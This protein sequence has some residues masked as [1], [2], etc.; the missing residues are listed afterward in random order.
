MSY[1]C[2]SL[3]QPWASAIVLLCKSIETRHWTTSYRGPLLIHAS[4]RW[5][6]EQRKIY[7][8][9]LDAGVLPIHSPGARTFNEVYPLGC[10]LGR[11]DLHD[12]QP[13][14]QLTH[15]ISTREHA[16]GDYSAGRFGWLL[17]N[18]QKFEKPIPYRGAQGIFNVPAST[19][20]LA[21][22]LE[23]LTQPLPL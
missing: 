1:K 2:L 11:V 14:E 10:I 17:R 23:L 18:V 3:W 6:G 8:D 19:P 9:L 5:T 22:Q 13:S 12:I 15:S 4:K 16:L 21:E 20:R 7:W